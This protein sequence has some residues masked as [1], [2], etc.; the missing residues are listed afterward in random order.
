MNGRQ[1]ASTR[2]LVAMAMALCAGGTALAAEPM[3]VRGEPLLV[4]RT[5][6][7]RHALF[8]I[9]RPVESNERNDRLGIEQRVNLPAVLVPPARLQRELYLRIPKK[10]YADTGPGTTHFSVA[11]LDADWQRSVVGGRVQWIGAE[12]E[13]TRFLVESRL[14]WLC[15]F[16][17]TQGD[18]GVTAFFAPTDNGLFVVQGLSYGSNWAL[19]GGSLR[20]ELARGWSAYTTYDVQTNPLQMIQIGSTGLRYSW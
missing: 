19:L 12:D 3:A 14:L 8:I 17:Q 15:E 16:V 2:W 7:S 5:A 11:G 20:W 13:Q 1:T 10:D 18:A 4:D 9:E 6:D